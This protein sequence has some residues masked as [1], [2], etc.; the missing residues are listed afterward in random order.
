MKLYRVSITPTSDFATK[1]KGDTLFGQFCWA[2][3][4]TLD[5]D[6]LEKLLKD[7]REQKEPF[8]VVSDAFTKGYFPKPKMPSRFL[9]EK[10]EDKKINR[11]KIWL[12]LDNLLKGEYSQAKQDKEVGNIDK[13]DMSLHNAL[14]Y[15]SFH[16]GDGF[17]PYALEVTSLSKK[18]IYFLIDESQLSLSEFKEALIL[19]GQIGYGKKSTIGKGRFEIEN[20]EEVILTSNSSKVFMTLSPFT[21][22]GINCKEIYYEPF[23]RFGKFGA[24]R[25]YKSPFKK[26]LL[27]ADVASVVEFEDV[28]NFKYLG[29]AITGVSD[30]QSYTDTVHQ[31]YSIV[32]PLKELNND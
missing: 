1:I 3:Y 25:V 23:T 8:L 31:G 15:K 9:G 26:P 22:K 11:K 19:I 18:D 14:N 29:S 16:T 30:N 6:R 17:D 4:Y 21:P 13:E 20:I 28:E 12:T 7:Y 27:L 24:N 2:I 32:L 10:S 5:Q